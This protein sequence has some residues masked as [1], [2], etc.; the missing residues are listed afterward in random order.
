MSKRKDRRGPQSRIGRLASFYM[1]GFIHMLFYRILVPVSIIYGAL[2][3]AWMLYP[4]LGLAVK[5]LTIAVWVLFT[6]QLFETVK[7]L[8]LSRSRGMAFGHLNE[9]FKAL[10]RARYGNGGWYLGAAP[11]VVLAVWLVGFVAMVVWWWP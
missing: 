8:A 1:E 10:Y 6:P 11:Y 2:V 7:G 4:P 9:E 3:L 5:A